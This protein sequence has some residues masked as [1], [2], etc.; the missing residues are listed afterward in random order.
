MNRPRPSLGRVRRPVRV[1]ALS[2]LHR[3]ERG[4]AIFVMLFV[5]LLLAA[6][7]FLIV[8]TGLQL[9]TKVEVQSAADAVAAG[10]AC[11][12]ARGL[13]T[14]SM[15]NVVETQLLALV[16]LL[17]SLETVVP[18]ATEC[19]DDLVSGIGSSPVGHDVPIDTR[20][21]DWLVVGNAAS[22]QEIIHQF[23]DVVEGVPIEEF[24]R[25]DT[26]I[27]WECAK[28]MDGF[29]HAMT[30]AVP[31]AAQRE[32]IDIANEDN[33]EFGL[34]VPV[35][36]ELP[37]VDGEFE[38]FR[39]PMQWAR[40]PEPREKQVIGGFAHVMGY[41]GYG[42]GPLGP[43]EYWREPYLETR[44]MGL[45]DISRFSVLF[46]IVSDMK[47]EM[48]FGSS[49]DEVSLREWEM[50]YEDALKLEEEQPDRIR[51]VWWERV[52]FDCRYEF[53]T[54]TFFANMD[55]RHPEKPRPRNFHRSSVK[56]MHLNGWT[57]SSEA[58]EGL[59]PRKAGWYKVNERSTTHYPQL[60]IFAPH[61]PMYPDGTPWPYTEAEEQTYYHVT[62]MRFN[63]AELETDQ[64]LHRD[65]LPPAGGAPDFA[66][67]L[68][69]RRIADLQTAHVQ[70]TF[71]FNGFAYRS[72]AVEEWTD[73]FINPNPS[74]KTVC[75][76][77]TRVYNRWSHDLFTQ[78]WKVKLMR[79]DRWRV[80]LP[81]LARSMPAEAGEVGQ[82]VTE[83][84]VR[85][86]RDMI[87]AYD[88]T[89]VR[90]VTH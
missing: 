85:P 77:Q 15:C 79:T 58:R 35:W 18:P 78:H 81:E 8:N 46:R 41:R 70:R 62:L 66:P 74:S 24:C 42:G 12:Y 25:Y 61:P 4:Q 13:N 36:P 76:A 83:E 1:R 3:D 45:F 19:I 55:L 30:E 39:N 51:R 60:G 9:N 5:F 84:N 33:C 80:L 10:G 89:F 6:L 69:D 82:V 50:V 28:L 54:A 53:P 59:D 14:V 16:L 17:D 31:R 56:S 72:G 90:E 88:D 20:V 71:T 11:W 86:I 29:S 68:L 44:P 47:L 63:G 67:V 43:F 26:G 57:R 75:Y 73:W 87:E 52:S 34:L 32:A 37:V 40:M 27:L 2:G 23:E 65:Y 38:D 21:S 22:E 48:M 49:E 7:V 64:H